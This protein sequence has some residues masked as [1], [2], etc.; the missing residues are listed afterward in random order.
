[1]GRVEVALVHRPDRD[2]WSLPKGKVDKGESFEQCALREVA[3]ETGYQCV[4]GTF[5]GTVEYVDGKGRPKVVAYWVM[6]P[7]DGVTFFDPPAPATDEVD[8]L[9][10]LGL[11]VASRA[12]SYRHDRELL[13]GL[14]RSV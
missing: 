9:R 8:E 5:A 11:T 2:D 14:P 12:L 10:W 13:V 7:A 3:E 4:L 6:G 1:V